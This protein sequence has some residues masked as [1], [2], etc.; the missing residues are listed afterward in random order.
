MLSELLELFQ[1]GGVLLALAAKTRFLD[2][3]I[4]ELPLIGEIGLRLDERGGFP[5]V[6]ILKGIGELDS[7]ESV[8]THFE[9]GDSCQT[10]LS[11]GE[12]LDQFGFA[13]AYRAQ[14]GEA[15]LEVEF[16]RGGFFRG[17]EHGAAGEPGF[18]CV[19]RGARFAF[20]RSRASAQGGVATVGLQLRAGDVR[21][22]WR[23]GLIFAYGQPGRR[24][25]GRGGRCGSFLASLF[26]CFAFDGAANSG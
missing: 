2:A 17:Q 25:G 19:A 18:E 24:A 23:S 12:R 21:S 22:E 15:T 8:N 13:V 11:I 10:P 14:F 16:I 5:R 4:I 20:W 26:L 7:A 9:R 6:A 1:L 3:E